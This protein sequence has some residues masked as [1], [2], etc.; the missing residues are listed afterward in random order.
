V[1]HVVDADPQQ[2]VRVAGHREHLADLRDALDRAEDLVDVGV[3]CEPQ[4]GE[5]LDRGPDQRV[6]ERNRIPGDHT[7]L[8]EPVDAAFDRRR[9]EVHA[10]RDVG[11]RA[12]GVVAQ[13][14]DDLLVDL[15][16]LDVS[17]HR[18]KR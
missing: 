2:R 8:L 18:R 15:I 12:A 9:R 5:G 13:Q 14:V 17:R 6:V 4:L 11:E 3:A 10:L 16:E 1:L 7:G